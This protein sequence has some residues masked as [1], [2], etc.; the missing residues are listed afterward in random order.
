M[1]KLDSASGT[2]DQDDD[3]EEND[4]DEPFRFSANE[5]SPAILE[6]LTAWQ[7]VVYDSQNNPETVLQ[8]LLSSQEFGCARKWADIYKADVYLRQVRAPYL[9][10]FIYYFVVPIRVLYIQCCVLLCKNILG[11]RQC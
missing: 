4:E 8:V 9:Y 10:T 1:D 7:N 6:R 3:D 11:G 5:M 2:G